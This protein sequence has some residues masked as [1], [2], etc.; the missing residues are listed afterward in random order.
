MAPHKPY[1]EGRC[2]NCHPKER[3]FSLGED[4]DL[5]GRCFTCHEHVAFQA[6][7][8]AYPFVHGPVALR[9]CLVCHDPHESIYPSLLQLPDP[10]LCYSCHERAAVLSS[11]AH[12]DLSEEKCLPCHDPH[13]GAGPYFLKEGAKP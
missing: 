7:L 3:S 5:R 11:P 8:E 13:G 9:N 2:T 10:K 4:F 1:Q 6:R 12:Q